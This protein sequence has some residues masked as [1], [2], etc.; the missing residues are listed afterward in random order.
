MQT[1]CRSVFVE[2]RQVDKLFVI[3]Q[4]TSSSV[5]WS[6]ACTGHKL[7]VSSTGLLGSNIFQEKS[8]PASANNSSTEVHKTFSGCSACPQGSASQ[9]SSMLIVQD[10]TF[11]NN[12]FNHLPCSTAVLK[13]SFD[14]S[15][16]LHKTSVSSCSHITLLVQ[17]SWWDLIGNK[18][19]DSSIP[20]SSPQV[21][22]THLQFESEQQPCTSRASWLQ[23]LIASKF[24]LRT[25]AD[26]FQQHQVHL[27]PTSQA[28]QY[29]QSV[30]FT[31]INAK[32]SW[33][34]GKRYICPGCER[35]IT[36]YNKLPWL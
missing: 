22:S 27:G 20:I 17:R 6:A 11:D 5:S 21:Q 2:I 8:Y 13:L 9:L 32:S 31:T 34:S 25:F 24:G 26:V 1:S 3:I 28:C 4:S 12:R 33:A 19:C 29:D 7:N 30:R 23:G 35:K 18:L 36:Q 14:R 15:C 10:M 16:I